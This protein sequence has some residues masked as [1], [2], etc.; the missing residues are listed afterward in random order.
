[1]TVD[2]GRG[3]ISTGADDNTGLQLVLLLDKTNICEFVSGDWSTNGATK[4][5]C[6]FAALEVLGNAGK[7]G[8]LGAIETGVR[9][10]DSGLR[11]GDWK[12]LISVLEL[13]F[14][15]LKQDSESE[16]FPGVAGGVKMGQ[17]IESLITEND[18]LG[19]S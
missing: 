6:V 7:I 1:M 19:S 16:M 5:V 13:L 8:T 14:E 17:P 3:A 12:T 18:L 11:V 2:K 9:L 15:S 10:V 4:R